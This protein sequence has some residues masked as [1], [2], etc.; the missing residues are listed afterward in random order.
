MLKDLNW[1]APKRHPW[2]RPL[3]SGM[4][5]RFGDRE[6][7]GIFLALGKAVSAWEGVHVA[8]SNLYRALSFCG[9]EDADNNATWS[10]SEIQN[11]HERAK[12]LRILSAEFFAKI[13]RIQSP[14]AQRTKKEVSRHLTAYVEWAARRNDLAHGYVTQAWGEDYADK[15]GEGMSVEHYALCPSHARLRKWNN[16]EPEYNYIAIEIEVFAEHFQRLDAAFEASARKI[17]FLAGRK[18]E[19]IEHAEDFPGDTDL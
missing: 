4:P 10:F 1:K 13:E 14:D 12:K 11:V 5:N 8:A 15:A 3:Y 7:N 19:Y 2:S 18:N 16:S 6:P 9:N 17:N